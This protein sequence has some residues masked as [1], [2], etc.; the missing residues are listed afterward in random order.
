VTTPVLD[1]QEK[2][3]VS[4]L[5][6]LIAGRGTILR[7]LMRVSIE[8]AH[9]N[10]LAKL[11]ASCPKCSYL[12]TKPSGSISYRCKNS[13][14]KFEDPAYSPKEVEQRV[15]TVTS[16]EM[17]ILPL[18][19]KYSIPAYIVA[20]PSSTFLDLDF[21]SAQGLWDALLR[22]TGDAA[23]Y[24]N[25]R[26]TDDVRQLETSCLAEYLAGLFDSSGFANAGGWMP[27]T[28]PRGNARMRAYFQIV[29]NWNFVIDLDELLRENF[30]VPV[31]TIDWGHPNI[32]SSSGAEAS[33]AS[34][35]R[36]HQ[37]KVFPE[38]LPI[39]ELRIEHKKEML[40]ELRSFNEAA[41]FKGEIDW[42]PPRPQDPTIPSI[43]K[44]IKR[45]HFAESDARLPKSVRRHFDFS[46]QI[47]LAL[48]QPSLLKE[49]DNAEDSLLYSFTGIKS[50]R[51][52]S[53]KLIDTI[54]SL[55]N[56]PIPQPKKAV[57][58]RLTRGA[59]ITEA[60]TY[61]P[62]TTWLAEEMKRA[63]LPS[64]VAW[65]T[66][67]RNLASHLSDEALNFV[68][69]IFEWKIRPD[70][71]GYAQMA[72]HSDEFWFIE[73]KIVELGLDEVG[74]LLSYCLV[75]NPS[76][77]FLISTK[78][79]T[80]AFKTLVENNGELLRYGVDKAIQVGFMPNPG[81]PEVV[82]YAI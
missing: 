30:S 73:S 14:C 72:T 46:W 75:A 50:N 59:G 66:S 9:T 76:R 69:E 8:F 28:A 51:H 79:M 78:P 56:P 63:D 7:K 2:Q 40:D 11:P 35:G 29:K 13:E 20:T 5:C 44:G 24:V 82:M 55:R 27:G 10:E 52:D 81:A 54:E 22:L 70:V 42:F 32:R 77:A 16:I 34:A 21:S 39:L 53:S 71:V 64:P 6:G 18:C 57:R 49:Q 37:L 74:Q 23:S 15:S 60:S 62:L 31:Q 4:Y 26:M 1:I 25:I 48:G 19:E 68:D 43:A 36:E 65:D 38:H 61:A 58:A 41:G 3:F 33:T 17:N 67:S 12:M 47:N 80:P 45:Y